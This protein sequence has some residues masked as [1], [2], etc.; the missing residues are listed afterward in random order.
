MRR[1][2][3]PEI[4]TSFK[5]AL[6]NVREAPADTVAAI[7]SAMGTPPDVE[8]AVMVVRRG[9][10]RALPARAEIELEGGTSLVADDR[11][12]A[13]LPLG[14]HTLRL[15]DANQVTKLIVTPGVCHL[16]KNLSVWGGRGAQPREADRPRCRFQI[17]ERC[18]GKTLDGIFG[19]R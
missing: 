18:F 3:S 14:Y 17:E 10:Q 16:S 12:P 15:A 13:D 9:E 11:L 2:V 4:L 6:G 7:E 8:N 5:D 1:H 19:R